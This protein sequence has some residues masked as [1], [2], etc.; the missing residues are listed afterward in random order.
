MLVVP[1]DGSVL[2]KFQRLGNV[3]FQVVKPEQSNLVLYFQTSWLSY[4]CF[5]LQPFTLSD[6]IKPKHK[7]IAL[8]NKKLLFPGTL[9]HVVIDF[10]PLLIFCKGIQDLFAN[11]TFLELLYSLH[12]GSH[13][14][15]SLAVRISSTKISL[16]KFYR[17]ND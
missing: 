9:D 17:F 16:Y 4:G 13:S 15:Q 7:F 5:F 8:I 1:S 14:I 11:D 6:I 3:C 12:L 2:P 10:L